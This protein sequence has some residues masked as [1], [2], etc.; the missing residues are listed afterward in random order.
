MVEE[1]S[2]ELFSQRKKKKKSPNMNKKKPEQLI[3]N[4]ERKLI[5]QCIFC[6][7]VRVTLSFFCSI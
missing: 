7:N 4:M 5:L 3:R 1:K 6:V 2:V